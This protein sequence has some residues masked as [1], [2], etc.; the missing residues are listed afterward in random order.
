MTRAIAKLLTKAEA[1]LAT[2]RRRVRPDPLAGL[3]P[4]WRAY[5]QRWMDSKTPEERYS[6][7]L[8][9]THPLSGIINYE[10]PENITLQELA[11]LWD[12]VNHD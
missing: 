1:A 6:A 2:A 12:K 4:A 8:S 11:E 3:S 5:V 7:L 9:K 10:I